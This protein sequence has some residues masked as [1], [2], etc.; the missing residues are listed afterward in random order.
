[1]KFV[2]IIFEALNRIFVENFVTI[3]FHCVYEQK[4]ASGVFVSCF[5]ENFRK[6]AIIFENQFGYFQYHFNSLQ[7]VISKTFCLRRSLFI[8]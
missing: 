4:N 1:M 2:A 3:F 5:V 7:K 6:G 8:H